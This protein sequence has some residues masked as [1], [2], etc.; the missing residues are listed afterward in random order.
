MNLMQEIKIDKITLNIGAGEAG[1]KLD[2][3]FKLLK[4]ITGCTPVKTI[5]T[6]RIPGW[7][8]RPKLTI[9]TKVTLRGEKAKDLLKRLFKARNN[10]IAIKKFDENG[11]FSFGIK[12]Y[13]NIPGIEYN[14]EIGII[15]LEVAITLKRPG[16]RIKNRKI[17]K[18]KVGIK[19]RITKEQSM[20]FVKKMFNIEIT[21]QEEKDDY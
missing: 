5:T 11:N 19:H 7:N 15:G 4:E 2:K 17:R 3:A 21:E 20:E 9:G 10:K 8:I 13:L 16:F 6:K 14:P 1:D 12:E 18:G